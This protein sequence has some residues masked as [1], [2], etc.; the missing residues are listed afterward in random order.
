MSL[1]DSVREA[2]IIG[3]GGAGFPTH[4]K[5]GCQAEYVIG[6][7]AEC[8]PLL[9]VDQQLMARY[10]ED[11][12]AGI[13]AVKEQVGAKKAV[14]CLKEHYHDA[15][16]ALKKAARSQGVSV[17]LFKSYYPAGD[18][19]Q[20][21]FEVTGRVIPT[22][23]LPLD[24][25][26]VV[27]NVSTLVNIANA[28]KGK[29]VTDKMVTVG[30]HVKQPV[31][32]RVP[33]GTPISLLLQRAGAPENMDGYTVVI[34][35][36]CMG[37]LTKDLSTPV[38]KT[39]G[40]LL[41]IPDDHPLLAK[42]QD[43]IERDI[44][45]AKAVCCNCSMCTQMC[46]RNALGLNVQPHKAMRAV[47]QGSGALLG[48]ANSVFSCCDCGICTYYACNFGLSPSKIM[49]RLKSGMMAQGVKPQKEVPFAP[50][51]DID[52]KRIPVS[53]MIAR[54]GLS[55]YDVPAPLEDEL[56][57]VN[58]V[59]IP[60]KM[61]IGAPSTPVVA[62]GDSVNAGDL[63]ADIRENALGSKIHASISGIVS[64]VGDFIEIT[65]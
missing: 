13:A 42:K 25:G 23:G 58:Q 11:V 2:G 27:C 1:I 9:R 19:Q 65:M 45:L 33:I 48:T 55:K 56:M 50:D 28:L 32:L 39:T 62:V 34:G 21:V 38:T 49:Q 61:S 20:M 64:A 30:A 14:I 26:A 36:P 29:P 52:G 63:I 57:N 41:V 53:R 16:A 37:K 22:G 43:N 12:V 31:T 8:E 51:P 54:L 35:G 4:V 3:A 18:E 60:L 24:V 44:R 7:G 40:G 59:R 15:V 46:P 17:K 6:N 47:S 10:A 5:I